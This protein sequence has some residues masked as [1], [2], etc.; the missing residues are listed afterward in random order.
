MKR[1]INNLLIAIAVLITLTSC[2][3]KGAKGWSVSGNIAGLD[4]GVVTL[5]STTTY[6]PIAESILN[7]GKFSF[8][9]EELSEPQY[10]YL[11]LKGRLLPRIDFFI[12]NGAVDV[13]TTYTETTNSRGAKSARFSDTAVEG[14]VINTHHKEM[15]TFSREAT[16][17]TVNSGDKAL[18][19][20][21]MSKKMD[22]GK[23]LVY[24][25]KIEF[26]KKNPKAFYSAYLWI[27]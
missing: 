5:I 8:K 20:E 27:R 12:D 11:C 3:E 23:E 21:A 15:T 24:K 2:S 13:T 1:S 17:F 16:T 25:H 22:E 14:G 6:Q 19:K 7:D 18:D 26:I 10:V 9:G 4:T